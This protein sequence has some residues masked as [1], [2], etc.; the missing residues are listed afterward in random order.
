MNKSEV[1][2]FD[3]PWTEPWPEG[4]LESV[5]RC[6]VCDHTERGLLY[7]N[8]VDN[9]F[10][11]ARGKWSLWK[12]EKCGS[13]YLDPRPTKA[14]IHLAY[15][16][17]F[18]HQGSSKKID[19]ADLSLFRKLSRRLVNGY[20]NRRYG[21]KAFPA[22]RSRFLDA[23]LILRRKKLDRKFRHLPKPCCHPALLLDIGCGGGSFL[24]LARSCGWKVVG[25]DPD[26][27]AVA[28]ATKNGLTAHMGGIE[29]FDDQVELF[30]AI[31]M[32]HVIEH[33]H[34]PIHLLKRCF[35]LLKPGGR[36]WLETPNIDS[37]GHERY[38]ENW[39]GLETP[40]H[41]VLFNREALL[42]ILHR[43]GF[44]TVRDEVRPNPIFGMY[45]ESFAMQQGRSPNEPTIIPFAVKL[46]AALDSLGVIFRPARAEFLTISAVKTNSALFRANR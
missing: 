9:T 8:L 24:S 42:E 32:N 30:D 3:T 28:N 10:R 2:N 19:Y 33:A 26:P 23:Y 45:Q 25:I 18:T 20:T 44:D 46:K 41:L 6:P 35:S 43:V 11:A 27:L 14:S 5:S 13:S 21:T 38:K 4:G 1:S 34:D 22:S 16:N 40:R 29:Y 17:Y 7:E 15:I 31:T 39:R 36:L 37:F 12:C